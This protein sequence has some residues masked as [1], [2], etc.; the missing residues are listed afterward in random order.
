M[1]NFAI[2]KSGFIEYL[3]K[4]NLGKSEHEKY[5]TENI[6]KSIFLYADE[7][8]KYIKSKEINNENT[9]LS[10]EDLISSDV[11]DALLEEINSEDEELPDNEENLEII[12][13]DK[14][15]TEAEQETEIRPKEDNLLLEIISDLFNDKEFKNLIN[16]DKDEKIS[17]EELLNLLNTINKNDKNEE[18]LSLSDI[19]TSTKDYK[20]NEL[21]LNKIESVSQESNK[22]AKAEKS[23][24][25]SSE[26]KISNN[27][28]S[29][30]NSSTGSSTTK[31]APK[32]MEE[33]DSNELKAIIKKKENA[34]ENKKSELIKIQDGT[35]E[36]LN[37]LKEQTE[38]SFKTYLA[39]LETLEPQKA[40]KLEKLSINKERLNNNNNLISNHKATIAQ[41]DITIANADSKIS[42]LN[43]RKEEL[44]NEKNNDN[45]DIVEK[46]MQS[47]ENEIRKLNKEKE[48]AKTNKN[49]S[50][51]EITKLEEENNNIQEENENID[52]QIHAL[53]EEISK[54]ENED[55]K[56]AKAQYEEDKAKYETEK[57]ELE[58]NTQKEI[59]AI[60]DEL[61]KAQKL[62]T[63]AIK[64]E[65]KWKYS[66]SSGAQAVEW[67]RQYDDMNQEQMNKIFKEKGY[68]FHKG[69]W[70]A[71]FVAMVLGESMGENLPSWYK[72]ITNKAYCPNIQQA[73][74]QYKI[75][76][77]EAQT[78]DIVLFDWD[79]DGK[80]NHVGIFVDNGD[81]STTIR[82]IEGNTVNESTRSYSS[83]EEQI[84]D[85]KTVLGI[86]SIHGESAA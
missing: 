57:E 21:E 30:R 84:R 23:R 4:L 43:N 6:N 37:E 12:E 48:E 47:I 82:T 17:K 32:S 24:Q 86:Y 26:N 7:F 9:L 5:D 15:E 54:I 45:A 66:S 76:A 40:E 70:C 20:N 34:L 64:E 29:S 71:D 28:S 1:I 63:T 31:T 10:M 44:R 65:A 51:K 68:A 69:L 56:L 13:D 3:E 27:T 85:R 16:T 53:E 42:I 2:L 78:G 35:N 81:G 58:N 75:S 39:Q 72:D 55:L 59:N 14:M 25:T 49:I 62:L 19:V 22:E 77:E 33:M 52:E 67:A 80:A 79:N 38:S 73:G 18:N 74:K 8:E 36:K 50:E 46:S 60:T 61:G 41:H 11:L 83:V